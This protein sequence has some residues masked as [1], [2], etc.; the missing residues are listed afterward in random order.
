VGVE[1]DSVHDRGDE[2]RVVHDGSPLAERQVG[3][4]ADA[5]A[6]F[7]FGDDLEQQFCAAG[8]DLDVAQFIDLCRRRHR[9][10]YAD[11]ATMPSN[12][13]R[14]VRSRAGQARR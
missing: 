9:S 13:Q 10:I 7:S 11:P 5:G 8:V 1:G 14:G 2:A 12:Q 4:D 6:F 3:A